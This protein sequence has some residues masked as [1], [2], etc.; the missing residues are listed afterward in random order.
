MIHQNRNKHVIRTK[1]KYL[2]VDVDPCELCPDSRH[3]I[4]CVGDGCRIKMCENCLV[5]I[6]FCYGISN[7]YLI[8]DKLNFSKYYNQIKNA[9]KGEHCCMWNEIQNL[10]N[11]DYVILDDSWD[12]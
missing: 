9:L 8:S 3:D 7:W 11:E 6:I 12:Y 10:F 5:Q 2:A 1:T 4:S